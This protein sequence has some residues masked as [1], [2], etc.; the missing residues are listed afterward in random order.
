MSALNADMLQQ[1][2]STVVDETSPAQPPGAKPQRKVRK[3]SASNPRIESTTAVDP[4]PDASAQPKRPPRPHQS[5]N[6]KRVDRVR[7]GGELKTSAGDERVVTEMERQ[8]R[9]HNKQ[10]PDSKRRSV[11]ATGGEPNM[12]P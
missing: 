10:R 6:G 12:R 8:R 11:A 9:D 4:S 3:R 7:A 1:Q 5:S 2:S